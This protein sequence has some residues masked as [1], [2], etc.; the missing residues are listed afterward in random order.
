MSKHKDKPLCA[1]NGCFTMGKLRGICRHPTLGRPFKC[2]A[3]GNKKCEH[4]I[5]VKPIG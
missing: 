5:P 3:H 1:V 2:A 4:R